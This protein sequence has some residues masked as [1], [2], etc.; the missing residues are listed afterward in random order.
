MHPF[1]A[2]IQIK[3]RRL[4]CW[5]DQLSAAELAL[6]AL[7]EAGDADD[8]ALMGAAA[9]RLA[10]VARL[11]PEADGASLNVCHFRCGHHAQ[12]DRGRGEMLDVEMD[13]EALMAGRQQMLDCV[14]RGGLDHIDHDGCRQ[15]GNA[16]GADERRGLVGR[17]DDL[18]LSGETRGN[19]GEVDHGAVLAQTPCVVARLR[20]M[21]DVDRIANCCRIDC[22]GAALHKLP[23]I[24]TAGRACQFLLREFG[25]I[26]RLSWFPLLILNIVQYFAVRAQIAA[27][28]S[29]FESGNVKAVSLPWQWPIAIYVATFLGTAIVA[30]ALHRVILLGDRK[31]GHFLHIALG[32]VELLFALLPIILMVPIVIVMALVLG[33]ALLLK[34]SGGINV[35]LALLSPA[36]LF[37][38]VRIELVFPIAVLEGRYNFSE[39]W[40]LTR[41]NFWRILGLWLLVLI[42]F[43]IVFGVIGGVIS[44]MTFPFVGPGAGAPKHMSALFEQMESYLLLN[45]V[46]SFGAAIVGGA[47]GVGVLSYTYKALNGLHPDAVWTPES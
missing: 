41:G 38:L 16:A 36:W 10:L 32:K 18:G 2:L 19:A 27:M 17:D 45:L 3:R 26:L 22:E 37:V 39:S 43:L 8:H 23:V 11:D 5:I 4:A 12:A 20:P 31:P 44:A 46:V 25:T 35:I 28:R 34:S 15:H 42:P 14:E 1:N 33:A 9:D 30:V 6:H 47:L 7:V 13:A 29:A 21:V 24:E 40:S